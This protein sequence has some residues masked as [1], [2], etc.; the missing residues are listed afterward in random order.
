[1]DDLLPCGSGMVP[2]GGEWNDLPRWGK[3][4]QVGEGMTSPCGEGL[5][6]WMDDGFTFR[7]RFRF[8]FSIT[9]SISSS[10]FFSISI[11]GSEFRFGS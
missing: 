6:R 3:I 4:P 8:R 7:F 11:L 10:F 2:P 9:F 5:P 1:M